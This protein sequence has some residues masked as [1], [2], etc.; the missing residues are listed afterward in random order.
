MRAIFFILAVGL[1]A[2]AEYTIKPGA[3]SKFEL[4]VLKTGFMSG[5]VHIFTFEKYAGQLSYDAAAPERSSVNFAI[6]AESIVCHDTWVDEKDKKKVSAVALETM[7]SEKHPEM[8]FRSQSIAHRPDGAFDVAGQLTIKGIAKPITLKVTMAMEG[9]A[10]RF[11]G[12]GAILR[13]NYG[14]SPPS[15]VPFGLIGN[16]EEMPVHFEVVAVPR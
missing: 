16:K 8:T 11:K 9:R 3:D 12:D 1:A 6:Q 4:R 14:I 15:P 10:L 2:G 5:K 13:K 7:E